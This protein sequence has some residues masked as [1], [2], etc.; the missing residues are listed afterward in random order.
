[1]TGYFL[2]PD[3]FQMLTHSAR[4]QL[5]EQG[6]STSLPGGRQAASPAK[7]RRTLAALESLAQPSLPIAGAPANVLGC[8]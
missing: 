2:D 5:P 1:M 4:L 3:L 8:D 7:P 6:L